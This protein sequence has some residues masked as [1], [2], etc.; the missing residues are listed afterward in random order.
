MNKTQN[1]KPFD[2][3]L[4][5]VGPNH[6]WRANILSHKNVT[7]D[8]SEFPEIIPYKGNEELLGT[9]NDFKPKRWRAKETFKYYCVA[10]WRGEFYVTAITESND[11]DDDTRYEQYN[12]FETEEEAQEVLD[13]I[14][15]T[16]IEHGTNN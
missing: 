8:G 9:T 4:V 6:E 5:R 12:Y 13:I 2:K 15:K 14:K 7:V 10:M 3:V 16:L 11:S 1:L